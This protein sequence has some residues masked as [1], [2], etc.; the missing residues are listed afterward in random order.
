MDIIVTLPKS[1]GCE[2]IIV[3]VDRFS[4]YVS[5]I[6]APK[7]YSVE[8][9]TKLCFR[10]VVKYWGLPQNIIS[11]WDPHFIGKFWSGLFKLMELALHFY[12]SFIPRQMDKLRG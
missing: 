3:V 10:H 9:T 7:D 4:K 5:F 2:T 1:E 6:V 8:E 12:T 11:D